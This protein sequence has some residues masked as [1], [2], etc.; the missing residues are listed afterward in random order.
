VAK[1][2]PPSGT[3]TP[4]APISRRFARISARTEGLIAA[5]ALLVF[6][7]PASAITPTITEFSSGLG[8][9][10]VPLSV[11]TGSDRNVWFA[12]GNTSAGAIGRITIIGTITK[13]TTGLNSG[14]RPSHI[15]AGPDGNL[16]FTDDGT[17]A[18]IGRIDTA[19]H[20]TEFTANLNPGSHPAAITAGPD[21]NLWFTDNGS[22]PAIG[23]VKPDGSIHEFGG[24]TPGAAPQGIA[25]GPDGNLWFTDNG[26]APAIG[27]ITPSGTIHEFTGSLSASSSPAEIAAGPDGNLWFTDAG[28]P[29]A[30]GRAT[31]AGQVTEFS[32]GFTG[33]AD[34]LGIVA[35]PDGALWFGD[36]GSTTSGALGR[37]LTSGAIS[38]FSSGLNPRSSPSGVTVGPD[39][40]IWFGD[41]GTAPAIGMITTPPTVTTVAATATGSATAAVL[42]VVDGHTQATNFHVEY[43]VLGGNLASTTG[44]SLGTSN[45]PTHVTVALGKLRP[46]TT[47]QARMVGVNPTD[48]TAGAFVTFTTGPPADRISGMKLRPKVMVAAASGGPIRPARAAR[49]AGALVS[50]TGTQ[51]ATTTFTIEHAVIG[52]RQGKNCA[53][54]NRRNSSH[55]PCTLLVKVGTFRHKDPVGRVRFR[56]TARIHGRK[57]SPGNYR[58]DA[59]PHSAG[60]IGN[61]VHK[62]FSV[63]AGPRK[64]RGK[65]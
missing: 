63:K 9:S 47:Y 49:R 14:S 34:P 42:G 4:A 10:D 57:L 5:L 59:E 32:T 28:T 13:F 45:G 40:N 6:A 44:R 15:T 3:A 1:S 61:A 18:A 23:R 60:G 35:G 26:A 22:A 62:N 7:A 50:Y 21:G 43:G 54:R 27:R 65:H 12:D 39:G 58:L 56:F 37:A 38:E 64:K 19:G 48:A 51:P 52:R 31:T 46:N 16:W 17:T 25:S 11:A 30:I 8:S 41:T 2:S 24:L 53:R 20:I 29:K 55:R 33:V 36:R